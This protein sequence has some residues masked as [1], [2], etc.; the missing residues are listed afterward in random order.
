MRD[1]PADIQQPAI[2][3]N[4]DGERHDGFRGRHDLE[5]SI[6]CDGYRFALPGPESTR[7]PDREVQQLPALCSDNHLSAGVHAS[8]LLPAEESPCLSQRVNAWHVILTICHCVQL[9]GRKDAA[10][11]APPRH[12]EATVGRLERG[13]SGVTVESLAA[14]PAPLGVYSSVC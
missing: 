8:L 6:W 2:L 4:R 11:L 12:V 13:E 5:R 3:Q 10:P 14:I 7:D 1:R 9:R